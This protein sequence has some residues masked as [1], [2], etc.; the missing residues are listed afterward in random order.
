MLACSKFQPPAYEKFVAQTHFIDPFANPSIMP[1]KSRLSKKEEKPEKVLELRPCDV[2]LGRGNAVANFEGNINF[3]KVVWEHKEAYKEAVRNEKS[4]V[5]EDVIAEIESMG[6]R[7]VEPSDKDSYIVISYN[8]AMEKTSQALREKKFGCPQG[9]KPKAREAIK[10][11]LKKQQPKKQP[12]KKNKSNSQKKPSDKF[13]EIPEESE[14]GRDDSLWLPKAKKSSNKKSRSLLV[15]KSSAPLKVKKMRERLEE[16]PKKQPRFASIEKKEAKESLNPVAQEDPCARSP[17]PSAYIQPSQE[18]SVK[19][20][21]GYID[22]MFN[23]LPPSLTAFVS[24][25]FSEKIEAADTKWVRGKFLP[26]KYNI[27]SKFGGPPIGSIPSVDSED[28][29]FSESPTTIVDVPRYLSAPSLEAAH[30]LFL[31][32]DDTVDLE[33][34][35]AFDPVAAWNEFAINKKQE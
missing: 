35:N 1:L 11:Q 23:R 24:G 31:E 20:I 26:S 10:E 27:A 22:E 29:M 30:S 5:A 25:M 16:L 6:G 18:Q 32:D 14:L 8:R 33:D 12:P 4:R 13:A 9:F 28:H 3:R 34:L 17:A 7:F 15:K 2:L 19:P 21:P